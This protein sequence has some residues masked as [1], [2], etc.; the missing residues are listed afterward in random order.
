MHSLYDDLLAAVHSVWNR[1]WL[2]L[3]VAWGVCLLGWLAV[4]MVPNSYESR[5]R[6][7]V[8][9]D[10]AL[11]E[12]IGIGLADRKRDIERLKQTL[13][14]AAN[15]EKIVR[16]TRLG[17]TVVTPKDMEAAPRRALAPCANRDQMRSRARLEWASRLQTAPCLERRSLRA[18]GCRAASV[19]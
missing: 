14:S 16:S 8:Q 6:I 18:R 5:A 11:A 9:L 10:D 7:F 19:P 12:Q 4:A 17:E 13:T 15:L 3:A 1:R 2:A